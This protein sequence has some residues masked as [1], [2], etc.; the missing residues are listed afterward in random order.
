MTLLEKLDLLK[1]RTGDTNASLARN[2]G[3]PNTTIDG[4]YKKGYSNMKLSTVQALANYFDVS[5]DY[6]TKDSMDVDT[7]K[8]NEPVFVD[9]LSEKEK[10]FIDAFTALTPANR[11]T[12]LVIAEALLRDQSAR[13]AV[14]DQENGK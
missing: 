2:A 9:E 8:C 10:R 7:V 12:F 6:L 3:I 4:L 13:P 11:H 14:Q 1:K 5:V